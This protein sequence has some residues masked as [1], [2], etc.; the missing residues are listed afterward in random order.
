M[1]PPALSSLSEMAHSKSKSPNTLKTL[2]FPLSAACSIEFA[3]KVILTGGSRDLKDAEGNWLRSNMVTV[4]NEQGWVEELPTLIIA[5]NLHA[6]GHF[7]N[8]ENKVVLLVTGGH[9]N[10]EQVGFFTRT[11]S[12]EILIEGSNSWVEA[13]A[14]P[15]APSG[16]SAVS[17]NNNV[18]V[19]GDLMAIYWPK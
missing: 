6:C 10:E 18:I 15:Y 4:Y 9:G 12:T 1:T 8:S 11:T 5:R 19:T 13:G 2:L 17:I 16:M 14:L 3:D 7:I